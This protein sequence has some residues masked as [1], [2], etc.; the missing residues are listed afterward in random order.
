MALG[1]KG[2]IDQ[3]K[4]TESKNRLKYVCELDKGQLLAFQLNGKKWF[5]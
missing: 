5:T 3:W 4:K 2:Q 1:Q